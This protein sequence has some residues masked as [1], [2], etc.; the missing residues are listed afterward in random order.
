MS[1]EN[2][3]FILLIVM[4]GLFRLLASKASEAKKR[5]EDSDRRSATSPSPAEPI[6]RAPLESD[7]E[8]IRRFLK[9]LGQPTGSRPPPPVVPRTDVPP[10][11]LAPVQP[12][13]TPFAPVW[14]VSREEPR[15]R[16]VIV[17]ETPPSED[18]RPAEEIIPPKLTGPPTFEVH[19]ESLPLEPPPIVKTPTEAYAPA[20]RPVAK[21][22]E[23]KTD[24][25][26]LLASTS[27][28]RSAIILR[29][30]FGPP[31]SLQPLDLVGS[32]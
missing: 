7:A 15:K 27:G 22:E 25:A 26:I 19:E 13:I 16:E 10:R 8:R 12:P 17:R 4:A 9:A 2:L 6:E 30:I 23:S 1:I 24:I 29:E 21:G 14:K 32:A 20:T 31:R 5:Q 11:P 18:A 28:L 3:L